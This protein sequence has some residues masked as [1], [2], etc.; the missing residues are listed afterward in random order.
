MN[1][2]LGKD[3]KKLKFLPPLNNR[4]RTLKLTAPYLDQNFRKQYTNAIFKSKYR[5]RGG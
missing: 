4:V 2:C 1:I 3:M 5:R